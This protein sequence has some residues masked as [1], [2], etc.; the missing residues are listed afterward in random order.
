MAAGG[1][2]TADIFCVIAAE[3]RIPLP[4]SILHAILSDSSLDDFSKYG[5]ASVRWGDLAMK[6]VTGYTVSSAETRRDGRT[7][8]NR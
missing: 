6:R 7:I 3:S 1:P 2:W 4:V 8:E 5:N